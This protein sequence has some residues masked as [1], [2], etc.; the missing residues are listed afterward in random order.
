MPPNTY[1]KIVTNKQTSLSLG[2]SLETNFNQRTNAYEL[3]KTKYP[4]I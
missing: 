1:S 2:M 4:M 3:V